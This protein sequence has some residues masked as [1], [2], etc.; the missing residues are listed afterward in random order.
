[1]VYEYPAEVLSV[2]DG[3]TITVDIDL[4]YKV[5]VRDKV[6]IYGIDTPEI[7]TRDKEEKRR[8]YEAK[9]FLHSFIFGKK[10]TIK[11]HK[12]EKYGRILAD[13]FLEE[14]GTKINIAEEMIKNEYAVEY[15]GGKR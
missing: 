2:Y 15:Y 4:G 10:V 12:Q 8:G 13:V 5:N 6:R 14:D 9:K 7:R 1:M 3:D 11:T